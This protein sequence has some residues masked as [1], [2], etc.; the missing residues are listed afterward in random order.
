MKAKRYFYDIIDAV[1]RP[2]MNILPGNLAYYIV[3]A[4]IPIIT[5][6]VYVA[7]LFS[8][9]I[10]LVIELINK[11]IPDGVAKI[12]IDAI[13]GKG[14][15]ESVGLFIVLALIISSNGTYAMIKASNA[16]YKIENAEEMKDRIKSIIILFIINTPE[17]VW[18]MLS[19]KCASQFAGMIFQT[20]SRLLFD[21]KAL[22]QYSNFK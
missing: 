3:L 13:S 17:R 5:I 4:L 2:E 18:K 8:I 12:V 16:L 19:A 7:S 21:K 14:F 22:Q 9:S 10:D 11:V 1:K 15:D 20:C 6:I